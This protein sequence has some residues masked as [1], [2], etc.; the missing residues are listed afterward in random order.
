[1]AEQELSINE[2][3]DVITFLV[4]CAKATNTRSETDNCRDYLVK[5]G[6]LTSEITYQLNEQC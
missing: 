2:K 3:L 1:M 5:I 6:M 4:G